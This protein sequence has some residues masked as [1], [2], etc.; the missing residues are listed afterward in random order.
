MSS[1]TD[2]SAMHGKLNTWKCSLKYGVLIANLK[3]RRLEEQ[4]I[5]DFFF[6]FLLH[7]AVCG[8]LRS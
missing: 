2:I 6:L 4:E 7:C 3:Y 1:T 5:I 8:I